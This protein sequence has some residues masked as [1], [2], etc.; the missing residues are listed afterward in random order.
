VEKKFLKNGPK[1]GVFGVRSFYKNAK[2]VQ[3]NAKK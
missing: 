3:K 1:K 2:K